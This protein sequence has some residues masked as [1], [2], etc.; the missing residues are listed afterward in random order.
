MG[1]DY[2]SCANC[3]YN[4]PDCGTY[5]SCDCGE[6]FCSDKCGKREYTEEE[7]DE[8]H[9][10]GDYDLKIIEI[11]TCLFCREEEYHTDELFNFLLDK[12]KLT[13][14]EVIKLYKESDFNGK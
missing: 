9:E 7:V 10:D 1:I 4:F 3:G 6:H 8:P 2:Y 13:R 5:F 11:T 12:F 14:E